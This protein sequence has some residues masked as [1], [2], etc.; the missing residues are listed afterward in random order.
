M[1]DVLDSGVRRASRP[2][3]ASLVFRALAAMPHGRL[4]VTMPDGDVLRFGSGSNPRASRYGLDASIAIRSDEFFRRCLFYGDIG[5]AEAY[6]A[7]EWETNDITE[8]IAWFI[9]NDSQPASP[10]R[11]RILNC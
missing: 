3:A 6:M 4:T 9:L 2:M 10:A 1:S 8:V 5:F 11:Q 7:G